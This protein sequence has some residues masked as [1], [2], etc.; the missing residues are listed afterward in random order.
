MQAA[1][2]G[3]AAC[4]T[5]R[6]RVLAGTLSTLEDVERPFLD[7]PGQRLACCARVVGDVIV[8]AAPGA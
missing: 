5:C 2:G 8:E 7:A 6:V 3:F 4:N 1:C